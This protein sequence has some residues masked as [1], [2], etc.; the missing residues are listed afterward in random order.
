ME[1]VNHKTK[2]AT[3]GYTQGRLGLTSSAYYKKTKE[4]R[5]KLRRKAYNLE[6]KAQTKSTKKRKTTRKKSQPKKSFLERLFDGC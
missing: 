2:L 1:V 3:I 6:K 5:L 4:E